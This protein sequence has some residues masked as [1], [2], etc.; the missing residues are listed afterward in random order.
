VYTKTHD[1]TT[2]RGRFLEVAHMYV[3]NYTSQISIIM[4]ELA[5]KAEGGM[6]IKLFILNYLWVIV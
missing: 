1:A 2:M 4:H 5:V 3:G 6:S